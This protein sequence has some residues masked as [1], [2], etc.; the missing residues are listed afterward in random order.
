MSNFRYV[1]QLREG[2]REGGRVKEVKERGR[3][4]QRREEGGR[5]EKE[6]S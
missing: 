5:E 6:S 4:G 3:E 1:E 2:G